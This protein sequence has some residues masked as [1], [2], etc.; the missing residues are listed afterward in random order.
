VSGR[1]GSARD[2]WLLHKPSPDAEALLFCF[3]YL[4]TGASLFRE[5][6]RTIGTAEVCPVQLPGR[7]NRLRDPAPATFEELAQA[8]AAGLRPYLD[9]P[10]AF[11]GHCGSIVAAYEA[12][13]L[14]ADSGAPTPSYFFVSSMYPPHECG[15]VEILE[16]PESELGGVVDG[17]LRARGVEADAEVVELSLEVMRADIRMFRNYGRTQREPLPCPGTAIAWAG[18]AQVPPARMAGWSDYGDVEL[19]I[20]EGGHWSFLACPPHLRVELEVGLTA[21]LAPREQD[22]L[23]SLTRPRGDW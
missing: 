6:P 23:L 11:V 2:R 7:E 20:L 13:L 18:D 17:L 5:W 12:A 14:L 8:I 9:R 3:P 19:S 15:R 21:A 16:T 10:F 22:G 4:G 1:A